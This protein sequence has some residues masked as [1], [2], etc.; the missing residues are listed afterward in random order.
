MEPFAVFWYDRRQW[1][2]TVER[3]CMREETVV[4]FNEVLQPD[5]CHA[6]ARYGR[7]SYRALKRQ[8][9]IDD[10]SWRTSIRSR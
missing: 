6:A 10:D 1:I 2:H 9:A 8:F 5:D 7:V 3:P 4:T